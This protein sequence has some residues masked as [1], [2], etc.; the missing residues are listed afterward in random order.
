MFALQ[1]DANGKWER[2]SKVLPIDMVF[3]N[4]IEGYGDYIKAFADENNSPWKY[5]AGSKLF[6]I[7]KVCGFDEKDFM[8]TWNKES[9]D[10]KELTPGLWDPESE[11]GGAVDVHD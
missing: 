7:K 10:L 1:T 11:M 2:Y 4:E 6:D 3:E 5:F 9:Q 8:A